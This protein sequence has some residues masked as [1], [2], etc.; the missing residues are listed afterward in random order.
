[1]VFAGNAIDTVL[2]NEISRSHPFS[3]DFHIPNS[4][5]IPTTTCVVPLGFRLQRSYFKK[6]QM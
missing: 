3:G 4:V 5:E 6:T 2:T 1:M